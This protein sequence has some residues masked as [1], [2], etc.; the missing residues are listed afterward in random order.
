MAVEKMIMMNVVGRIESLHQVAKEIIL[1]ENVDVVNALNEINESHFILNMAEE[2]VDEIV[3]MSLIELF[4]NNND[5]DVIRRKI[6]E[7]EKIFGGDFQ[8]KKEYLRK[9]YDFSSCLIDVKTLYDKVVNIHEKIENIENEIKKIDEFSRNFK[10]IKDI[11]IKIEELTELQYF[12]FSVGILSKEDRIKFKKNYENISAIVL[13]TGSSDFGEVCLVITPKQLELETNRILRSLNFHKIEL[14]KEYLGTPKQIIQRLEIRKN[15]IEK[16]LENLKMELLEVKNK[17]RKFIEICCSKLTMEERIDQLKTQ[18]VS[19]KNFFYLSGWITESEKKNIQRYLEKYEDIL[20]NF[21]SDED[22]R[23]GFHPPTKLKNHK[24]FRPFENIVKMYGIP[25]YNELDPTVFLS[26][27]YMMLFGMMFGD[28]G[29]GFIL[30]LLGLWLKKKSIN[31]A[32]GLILNRLG[33]SSMIFGVLYGS[34]FGFEEIIP[35]LLIKPFENINLVL[36]SAIIFGVFLLIISYGYSIVNGIKQREIKEG[37][38][39][40]NGVVGFGFYIVL[41]LMIANKFTEIKLIP[42][43]IGIIALIILAGVMLLREPL[44][45]LILN[46][47]PLYSE[48]ISSYYVE[49]SFEMLETVLGMLTSTISFIRVGAF[50]LTH[51]GL[52]VAFKTMSELVDNFA[53]SIIILVLGNVIIIGLEGLI[54]SIQGLRLEYYE[55]FSKYYKGEG[56]EFNPI[57][58]R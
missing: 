21:K 24:L 17:N 32:Y 19:T 23:E 28:L 6:E 38:F 42:N 18:M 53:G 15:K 11:D 29:Q 5:Y 4:N 43:T 44:T 58:V 48:E 33:I 14:T 31:K 54:V 37:I 36:S 8:V 3:D 45:N 50:A 16:E 30:F 34:V 2:N 9:E 47:R 40:R 51:V 22:V 27:T 41:L 12:T 26:L 46:K 1:L 7:V 55:L 13:H 20:I 25:S 52:F 35:A 10:Y 49:S 39:G 56:K 57:K